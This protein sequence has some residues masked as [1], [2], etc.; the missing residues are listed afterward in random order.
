[1]IKFYW[2]GGAAAVKVNNILCPTAFYILTETSGH[3]DRKKKVLITLSS[4]F[5]IR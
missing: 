3:S 2:L 4:L 1:M 5:I